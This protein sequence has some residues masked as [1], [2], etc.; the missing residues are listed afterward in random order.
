MP[1]IENVSLEEVEQG[2]HY[3]AG[4][5][6]MLIRICDPGDPPLPTAKHVFQETYTFEFLDVDED[7]LTNLGD[8]E[9]TDEQAASI[10]ELLSYALCHHINVV[11]HCLAGV[12]RSGAVAEVGVIMGFDDA[13]RFRI[14]NLLVKA[15]LLR[16][17][18]LEPQ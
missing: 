11:V 6:S 9:F 8:G 4:S 10:V 3:G 13:E 2:L 1:W 7:A 17:L 15:K 14:P 12:Y 18:G 16:V 5:R